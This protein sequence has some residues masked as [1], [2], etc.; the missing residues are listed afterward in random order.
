MKDLEFAISEPWVYNV[1]DKSNLLFLDDSPSRPK[2]KRYTKFQSTVDP[3]VARRD[4]RLVQ[5]KRD[6]EQ[7]FVPTI[8]RTSCKIG[9]VRDGDADITCTVG[10]KQSDV[11]I[12][13]L[14]DEV[15]QSD[16]IGSS[17]DE[18]CR[19]ILILESPTAQRWLC[20]SRW[21]KKC[22]G[23]TDRIEDRGK[24]DGC[25]CWMRLERWRRWYKEVVVSKVE[26]KYEYHVVCTKKSQGR[27]QHI[28]KQQCIVKLRYFIKQHHLLFHLHAL[29]IHSIGDI[30][31]VMK[32]TQSHSFIPSL[33]LG[34]EDTINF[35]SLHKQPYYYTPPGKYGTLDQKGM[36]TTTM[37]NF[38]TRR[39]YIFDTW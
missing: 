37:C 38:A 7:V 30:H 12:T 19:G 24:H 25:F 3:D 35:F 10:C 39:R 21:R 9:W 20:G 31:I 18:V 8:V 34:P 23:K 16:I 4:T 13:G 27:D 36:R 14:T 28:L 22:R 5:V 11:P 2:L 32:P 17:F 15:R 1:T 6:L 33:S 29:S 26:W